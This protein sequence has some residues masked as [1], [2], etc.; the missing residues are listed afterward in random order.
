V[1][2]AAF[3][4]RDGTVIDDMHYLAD[5]D[6][7][8]LLPGAA[9]AIQSLNDAGVLAIIVT[10]QS[11]IGRGLMTEAQYDATRRRL[12]EIIRDAGAHIDAQYHCP[13]YAPVNGTCE[14]RKPGVGM[15]RQAA[16]EHGIALQR[17]L[18]V[19]DRRSDV[20]PAMTLGGYGSL[21]PSRETSAEDAAWAMAHAR[22]EDSLG[23]AV[24]RY[25][26]WLA[27]GA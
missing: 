13:H 24:A 25:L 20:E 8:Q 1:R 5:A 17:S 3:L 23:A 19:G 14:C 10:N 4:D 22:V 9:T 16:G 2:T 7:I 12:A 26:A 21:V 18:Y 15:H 27:E 6:R 11:G